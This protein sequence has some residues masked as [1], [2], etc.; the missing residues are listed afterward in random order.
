MLLSLSL[1]YGLYFCFQR[2]SSLIQDLFL[3]AAKASFP[4]V[5]STLWANF[6]NH[7]LLPAL[8][9]AG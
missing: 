8:S 4:S 6:K 5:S 9:V 3:K 2:M 7:F 1:R